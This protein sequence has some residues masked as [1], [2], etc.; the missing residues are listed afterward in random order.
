MKPREWIN[1]PTD[2]QLLSHGARIKSRCVQLYKTTLK[3]KP[4]ID[5]ALKKLAYS[6]TV[7]GSVN[8]YHILGN[9]IQ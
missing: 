7:G 8:Y 3:H 9:T 2:T 1:L 6:Y 4:G 5:E